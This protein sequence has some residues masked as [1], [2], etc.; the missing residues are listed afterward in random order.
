M[1]GAKNKASVKTFLW[2]HPDNWGPTPRTLAAAGFFFAPEPASV[3]R[4]ECFCC[5]RGLG[6][7]EKSDNPFKE[8]YD[9]AEN[10]CAWAAARC[11]LDRDRKGKGKTPRYASRTFISASDASNC[12]NC[13]ICLSSWKFTTD[14]RHPTDPA[15]YEARL[16]TF[17]DW[18]FDND[19][20]STC[21]SKALARAGFVHTPEQDNEDLATC[22]YCDRELGGWKAT[23]DPL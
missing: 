11:S 1:P 13:S 10:E 7:W 2:P 23:D 17:H 16:N 9:R 4:V 20:R 14:D 12:S 15:R 21:T 3:D 22:F 5:K 18:P 6:S 19:R 8:H